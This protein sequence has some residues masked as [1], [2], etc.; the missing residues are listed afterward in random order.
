MKTPTTPHL[1]L[2][3]CGIIASAQCHA[4]SFESGDINDLLTS[5]NWTI[6][7]AA[8]GSIA[9]ITDQQSHSGGHAL[10]LLDAD[11]DGKPSACVAFDSN[12]GKGAL[13]LAIKE[14]SGA[15][16]DNPWRIDVSD[17]NSGAFNFSLASSGGETGEIMLLDGQGQVVSSIAKSFTDYDGAQWNAFSIVFDL[18]RGCAV[19]LN[20][21]PSP[22]LL[23]EDLG[24]TWRVGQARLS[25]GYNAGTNHAIYIDDVVIATGPRCIL[26]DSFEGYASGSLGNQ[27]AWRVQDV[28]QSST[29]NISAG[30]SSDGAQSLQISDNSNQDCP[31]VEIG[32]AANVTSG[33][34]T[35][36]IKES[37]ASSQPD[38]W[39]MDFTSVGYNSFNFSLIAESGSD[40]RLVAEGLTLGSISASQA[41]YQA[42]GWNEFRIVLTGQ[43][44]GVNIYLNGDATPI[45]SSANTSVNWTIGSIN[46]SAG[47]SSGAGDSIYLDNVQLYDDAL[48]FEHSVYHSMSEGDYFQAFEQS[49]THA[50]LQEGEWSTQDVDNGSIISISSESQ[51]SGNGSLLLRDLD[52]AGR[53]IAVCD[54]GSTQANGHFAFAIKE[55]NST[56]NNDL[57]RIDFS[58][59]GS[60]A[61]NFS[62]IGQSN[63]VL[64]LSNPSQGVL[65]SVNA[66][67]TSYSTTKW[68]LFELV[69][70][71]DANAIAVY[72]NQEAAPILTAQNAA[73]DWSIGRAELSTGYNGGVADAVFLD[74]VWAGRQFLHYVDFEDQTTSHYTLSDV[75]S[76]WPSTTYSNLN[77]LAPSESAGLRTAVVQENGNQSLQVLYPAD[78]YDLGGAQGSGCSFEIELPAEAEYYLSFDVTFQQNEVGVFDWVKGGKLP[79][80]AGGTHP[81]GGNY[82]PDGF[83]MRYM[84][85]EGG[86]LVIYAYWLDQQGT[87]S[88]SK[89]YGQDLDLGDVVLTPGVT[90][91]L[92]QRVKLNTPGAYD[93]VLQVWINGTM[94]YDDQALRFRQ[95]GANWLIDQFYMATFH[96]GNS[97]SWAP[98]RDNH[99]RFDNF[100]IWSPQ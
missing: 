87:V 33:S 39:R 36:A 98:P 32:A 76:D 30:E 70:S 81:S 85:K 17:L 26:Q 22:I 15:S 60:N 13:S 25:P 54:L 71:E 31:L 11:P 99:A 9:A 47:Y 67:N 94:V 6:S 65:A 8:N 66:A 10:Y 61:F 79:G 53:P 44:S 37:T 7:G 89:H 2:V 41:G 1:L 24:T 92:V 80:L 62:L 40:I 68:N 12:Q 69:H 73:V 77:G 38:L 23:S 88:G 34:L 28:S 78:H 84:W 97:A 96:G 86:R 82:S 43:N 90:Y 56:P 95:S 20:D 18:N 72:L 4:E 58:E 52:D 50:L 83:S 57:W 91:E 27:S 19:Y 48:Y 45:L 59:S 51:Y 49:S 100:R 93:G 42:T 63:G 5:G 75:E 21:H 29:V 46:L 74:D 16:S 3:A 55:S 14:V 35:F 64:V